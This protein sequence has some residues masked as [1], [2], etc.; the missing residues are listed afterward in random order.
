MTQSLTLKIKGLYTYPS[1]LSEVPEGALAVAD[2]IIIDRDS[3]A[4][5]RRGFGYLTHGAGVKSNFPLITDRANKYFFYQ[6]QTLAHY[7]LDK[8]GYHNELTG[9]TPY[10]GSYPKP[11]ASIPV[12]SAQANQN[13]YFTTGSGVKK[14]DAYNSTPTA[15]GVPQALDITLS[16]SKQ[17]TVTGNTTSTSSVITSV[18]S[19]VGVGV[20]MSVTGTGIPA[21]TFI[22]D[23]NATTIT[24]SNPAS[25][26]GTT[27]S[28]SLDVP[29]S[30]LS[31]S[32]NGGLNT[33]GYRVMWNITDTNKN[34]IQGAPSSFVQ[35]S[36]TTAAAVSI[37]INTTVPDGI[38]TSHK[39]QIYRSP[40]V[41]S[42]VTPS[43]EEQL[44]YEYSPTANDITYKQIS[45]LDIV[46]DALRG[47]TIYTAPSQQGLVNENVTPPFA[48]DIAV[49][50]NSLFYGNT[51]SLQSF[52]LTLLGTGL[53]TGLQLG[54]TL[55]IGGVVYT[56]ASSE[57]ASTGN[58]LLAQAFL[59][60]TTGTTNST[61][62]ITSVASLTGVTVGMGVTGLNIASG[63]FVTAISGSTVTLNQAATG[64]ASA[65]AITFVGDSASQAIRDT[66]LSLVK[67]INRYAS[68]TNYAYY[69]SG[70]SD[71]PG[72][73]SVQ[74]RTVGSSAFAV[75]SSRPS[76]WSPAL[77]A[78]GTNNLSTDSE[79]KNYIYF[80]KAQQP[81]AVP[82]GNFLPVGSADKNI[83]RI[84]ALRDSLFILKEDGVFYLTGTDSTN[85]QVWPLDY[86]TNIVSAESAVSLNNQIYVLT[87]QGIVSITQNGVAIMSR[88]IENN[89]LDLIAENYSG[90]QNTSF[91]VAYESARA[92]YLFCV[93]S[94]VDTKPTQY[95]RYNYVT[96]TWV[97]SNMNKLCG[98]VNP[99]ND[100]MYLGNASFPITD[101]ENKSLTYSDYADYQST[102][103]ISSVSGTSVHIT[104]SDTI[105]VG[106]IIFQSAN[107]F[108]TVVSVDPITGFLETTLPTGL[109]P[110]S[111]DVLSPIS[112]QI[113]WVPLTFGNPG[114][115]KQFREATPLF[116]VDFN[117]SATV[118][119]STDVYPGTI[120]ET[121]AGG[122]VGG[123][124]LFAW[125]GP[126]ETG[127][128][129]PWGGDPRRR[130][131]RVTVP[132]NHQRCSILNV[133]FSHSY[134]YSPWQ[135]QG[136]SLTGNNI[137]E[138]T[139]N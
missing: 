1:D 80:S 102:Q 67:V 100:R 45:I 10:T 101:V 25:A 103:T 36:N 33:T 95:Y 84:I 53:P 64:S 91:G 86:T 96:N 137:S 129:V 34:L 6:N 42:G 93:G 18:S 12:R 110:G 75:L 81:E 69:T 83:L 70:V 5:P 21:N 15:V 111:A 11:A 9:W 136:I 114:L 127:L 17:I 35:I 41:A 121:I 39:L 116:K 88:P 20:G 58:F 90:L 104:A 26:S 49:F 43:D 60:V 66:A 87:T 135:I 118:G 139:D 82:P 63:T 54:D 108:G 59:L 72:R 78:S 124:G 28:L 77:L 79:N 44:V 73:I 16:L 98:G 38:T 23:F 115:L 46:P 48:Y 119:F 40:A 61:T 14:L 68:S 29:S 32:V 50:R 89:L 123:W 7:G 8:L 37:I 105:E 109:V 4:E 3:I 125:G 113:E 97:H 19:V 71:L 130:P 128:G 106:S 112:T 31:T 27:V 92:Y 74:S 30:W 47:A 107:V 120:S 55:T 85:Y 117:G 65:Q 62:S 133:S 76:C 24:I 94:S 56:A 57:N 138:R 13:F 126:S 51:M 2:N 134:A 52:T 132:R 22:T 131:I 122:N 99:L